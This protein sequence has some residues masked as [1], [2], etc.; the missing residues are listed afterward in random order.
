M[1]KKLLLSLF[2]AVSAIV[3]GNALAYTITVHNDTDARA[4]VTIDYA[5]CSSDQFNLNSGSRKEVAAKAC[6]ASAVRAL[7]SNQEVSLNMNTVSTGANIACKTFE[8]YITKVDGVVQIN[9]AA[10]E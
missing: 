3:S 10:S 1:N 4:R 7:V 5:A 9:T 8:V 6:C 2:A